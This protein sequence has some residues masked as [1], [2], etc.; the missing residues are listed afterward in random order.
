M[1][2]HSPNYRA[3]YGAGN[4]S[5]FRLKI[6]KTNWCANFCLHFADNSG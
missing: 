3:G 4:Y 2:P 6:E 5:K 1:C